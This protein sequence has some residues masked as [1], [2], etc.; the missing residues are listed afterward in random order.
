MRAQADVGS[1]AAGAEAEAAVAAA[2][3][4]AMLQAAATNVQL[5]TLSGHPKRY[6]PL[7]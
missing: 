7:V 3:H 4:S 1:V 6:I 2:T 5:L